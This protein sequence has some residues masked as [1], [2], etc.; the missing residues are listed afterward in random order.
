MQQSVFIPRLS[1]LPCEPRVHLTRHA[2][3]TKERKVHAEQMRCIWTAVDAGVRR[4]VSSIAHSTTT[5]V[6]NEVK[7]YTPDSSNAG[8][9]QDLYTAR[10]DRL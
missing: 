1:R 5:A 4:F 8:I 3:L 9:G 2:L 7:L 10:C 6:G